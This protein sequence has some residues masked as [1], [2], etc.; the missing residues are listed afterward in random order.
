MK[1][2]GERGC[3]GRGEAESE[4]VMV[5]FSHR[6]SRKRRGRGEGGEGGKRRGRGEGGEGGKRRRGEGGEGR[7][8]TAQSVPAS[9]KKKRHK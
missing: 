8:P 2:G 5:F 3:E 4:G 7:R 1:W 9:K 6:S